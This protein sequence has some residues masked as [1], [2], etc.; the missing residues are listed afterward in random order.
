MK[1]I[2][3]VVILFFMTVLTYAAV[4][5]WKIVPNESSISFTA[6]QNNAPMSGSFKTFSGDI[7]FD[8][9]Q[10]ADSHVKINIALDSV[11]TSYKE[12]GDT[13]KTAD[14]FDISAFPQAVFTAD[15]FKKI[16]DKTFEADGTLTLRDKTVPVVLH[17]VLE[18]YSSTHAR[19][20]GTVVLK[21][22]AFGVGQ[23]DWA[24]TDE[25]KDEVK[26]EFVV[27]ATA[28]PLP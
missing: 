5:N 23:G 17:F 14:W 21:R 9:A 12:V 28:Y 20:K 6:T 4:P 8:P 7:H 2:F 1:K 24:K 10:L 25:I 3:V 26:V 16:S 13:L 15:K 19:A 27:V 22:T 18:D 11:T